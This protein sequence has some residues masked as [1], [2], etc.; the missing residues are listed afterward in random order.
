MSAALLQNRG[1]CALRTINIA[2][3]LHFTK[4][5][6]KRVFP[7]VAQGQG[8]ARARQLRPS[9]GLPFSKEFAIIEADCALPSF[10]SGSMTES[11][12]SPIWF[13][14][15]TKP[16][17]ASLA[18]ANL[19]RQGFE[20]FL[21]KQQRTQRRDGRFVTSVAP[22]FPGY[23]FVALAEASAPWRKINSTTGVSRLVAFDGRPA[24]VPSAVV[25]ALRAR[26][27]A[28]G[29]MRADANLQGGDVV[30]LTQG[31]FADALAK[32]EAAAPDARIYVLMNIMGTENRIL[33][34]KTHLRLIG[35]GGTGA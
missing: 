23:I 32:I 34:P 30:A 31:P 17:A 20:T 5:Q 2:F 12:L 26:C 28:D 4:G 25:R 9:F 10:L 14:A 16:N 13:L 7:H 19:A 33:V 29:V 1:A 18:E 11:L 27:D 22:L 6:V 24:P 35:R 8:Y 15:Q 21:P 3:D